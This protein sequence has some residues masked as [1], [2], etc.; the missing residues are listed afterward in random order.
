LLLRGSDQAT[1]GYQLFSNAS[2]TINWGNSA[3]TNWITGTGTGNQQTATIYAQ[4]PG[5]EAFYSATNGTN[6]TDMVTATLS[7]GSTQLTRTIQVTL[8][9]VQP[10]CGIGANSLNFGNYTGALLD[11]TTTL[12]VACTS[13]TPY[14]V[15]LNAGT[16]G[17]ITTRQ[18]T[19]PGGALLGYRLFSNPGYSVNWGNTVG[20]DTVAGN[21][22]NAVQILTV[23]GQIP[24]GQKA[25]AGTYTDTII[26]TLTY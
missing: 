15:G 13:G 23:Y 5:A 22:N 14:N 16:V 7:Y 24:S 17:T 25:T 2:Y 12:Q 8:Q 18:M 20:T 26:A 3:G 11:A 4:I 1:L 6:F 9:E 21:G 19:G 10:G